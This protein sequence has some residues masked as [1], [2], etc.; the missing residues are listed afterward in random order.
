[1]KLLKK[2]LM[3][4]IWIILI[5][6]VTFNVYNFV[7]I[8]ILHKDLPK[9]FDYSVLEVVSGSMEP[10][11]MVGDLIVIDTDCENYQKGDIIT[12]RDVNGSFVTHRIIEIDDDEMVTK[13]D[14][15][16]SIDEAMSTAHIVGKY[17]TKIPKA[18]SI[19]S[20]LKN[21]L[22]M[23][24]ILAIGIIV[25]LLVSTDSNL[26]PKLTDEEKE[27]LEFQNY[28]KE[29]EKKKKEQQ[30]VSNERKNDTEVV[31][32]EDNVD[33]QVDE[34]LEK[35]ENEEVE[36]TVVKQ[37]PVVKQ[38]KKKQNYKYNNINNRGKSNYNSKNNNT[39]RN[40]NNNKKSNSN[41][42]TN[43]NRNNQ[44]S[45]QRNNNNKTNTNV[46]TNKS[47]VN[48]KNSKQSVNKNKNY[49]KKTTQKRINVVNNNKGPKNK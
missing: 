37:K 2:I 6:L 42:K 19:M 45:S 18:G 34:V 30:S 15:N 46:K 4:F 5:L 7:S 17:V 16:D 9:I 36:A 32:Q 40:A 21:P 41:Y 49:S 14:A 12:F 23:A 35:I 38:P 25:C 43:N 10:T 24:L 8:N 22:V 47:V 29:E 33:N 20:S 39:Y 28:K 26:K 1:M 31:V 27:F 48:N 3:T 11:I 44:N 13:G